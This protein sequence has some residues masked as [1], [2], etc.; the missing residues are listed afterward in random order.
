MNIFIILINA[1][2]IIFIIYIFLT[3]YTFEKDGLEKL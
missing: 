1:L 2:L 3:F